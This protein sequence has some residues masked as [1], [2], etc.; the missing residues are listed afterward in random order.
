MR[1]DGGEFPTD[2][3][4]G[5]EVGRRRRMWRRLDG[6]ERGRQGGGHNELALHKTRWKNR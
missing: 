2:C 6:I 1:C 5:R 4:K 3:R